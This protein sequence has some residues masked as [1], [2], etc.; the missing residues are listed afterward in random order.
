MASSTDL[1]RL[2]ARIF[3]QTH[4]RLF[5]FSHPCYTRMTIGAVGLEM[6]ARH[7]FIVSDENLLPSLQRR[8][9]PSSALS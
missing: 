6:L 5:L 9:S 7:K 3:E 1:L 2:R 8:Q 4:M